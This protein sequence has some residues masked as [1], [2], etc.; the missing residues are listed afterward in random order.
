LAAL[1]SFVS[2]SY[3]AFAADDSADE[4]AASEM[5]AV[6]E[7]FAAVPWRVLGPIGKQLFR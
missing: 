4:A 5:L 1:S 3:E 2:R 7:A 6:D